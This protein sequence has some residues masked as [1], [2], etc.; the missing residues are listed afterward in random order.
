MLIEKE[1]HRRRNYDEQ[2]GVGFEMGPVNMS[3]NST[4]PPNQMEFARQEQQQII[5]HLII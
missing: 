3:A 5:L 4:F 1:M 2:A